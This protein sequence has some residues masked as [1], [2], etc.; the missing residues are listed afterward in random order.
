M[1]K[2]MYSLCCSNDSH[3][4]MHRHKAWGAVQPEVDMFPRHWYPRP[5]QNQPGWTRSLKNGRHDDKHQLSMTAA[6]T[7]CLSFGHHSGSP[8]HSWN[9]I[10]P[11]LPSLPLSSKSVNISLPSAHLE[12]HQPPTIKKK[13]KTRPAFTSLEQRPVN[14]RRFQPRTEI[15]QIWDNIDQDGSGQVSFEEFQQWS[16]GELWR[17]KKNDLMIVIY[18][19]KNT[20][21]INLLYMS[22]ELGH[23]PIN[24]K[25]NNW[26]CT[27]TFSSRWPPGIARPSGSTAP[28]TTPASSV[29]SRCRHMRAW[30]ATSPR[31]STWKLGS[32]E[33]TN[34]DVAGGTTGVKTRG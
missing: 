6:M 23:G 7:V 5:D 9:A 11:C 33:K 4:P 28:R 2:S 24:W 10:E 12:H 20:S 16:R 25:K 1:A 32:Y 13:K 26:Y 34:G 27:P 29:R 21:I 31:S 30:S 8:K 22:I 14:L 3:Q 18:L 19:A 15:W 17:P